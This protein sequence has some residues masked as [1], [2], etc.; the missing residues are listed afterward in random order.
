MTALCYT[1]KRLLRIGCSLG[2]LCLMAWPSATVA[3][4]ITKAN[5]T[6]NIGNAASWV[7]GVAPTSADVMLFDSTIAAVLTTGNLSA[8]YGPGA[9]QITNIGGPLTIGVSGTAGASTALTLNLNSTYAI[10]MSA[11]TADVT[12]GTVVTGGQ[13]RWASAQFGGINVAAGRTL[14]FN[15]NFN[16]QGSTKT[17]AM[18]GGGNIIFNG[19]AGSGGA[20]GFSIQGGTTVTMNGTGAWSGTSAKE[21]INGTLNLGSDTALGAATLTLGGT[22][23]NTPALAATGGARTIANNVTLLASSLGGNPTIVGSNDLTVNGTLTNSGANR[24]L[25]VNNTGLTT[26]GGAVALSEGSSNRTLTLDGTGSITLSGIVGDG[27]TA[28]AS[29]LTYAGS[30][31]LSLSNAN[32]FGG[33]LTATSGT[34]RIDNALAAQNATVSVGSANAVTFGTGITSATFGALSGSGDLALTNTDTND[35]ALSVGG[36][37]AS[38]SYSGKLSGAGTLTK[39]GTGTLTLSGSTSGTVV[40][41][42][43]GGTIALGGSGV[44]GVGTIN[45]AN[46][47]TV[48][49]TTSA[50]VAPLIAVT[51][52]GANVT[53]T[54]NQASNGF[55]SSF[56]GSSDQTLTIS[57]AGGQV[58]N[59]NNTTKQLQGFSG[60]VDLLA[61]ATL[62]DR[63][64][65]TNWQNGSD[66]AVFNV[67]G[68]ITSRNGGNWFLGALTGS[69]TLKM[70]TSGSNGIGLSYSIGARN[71]DATFAGAIEDGDTANGKIVSVTK[72]GTAR[73]TL[74]G[75][76]TY[77]GTTTISAGSLQVGASGSGTTGTGAV[78]VQSGGTILG[79]G[80]VQGSSFTAASG[81]TVQAGDGAAQANYGTLH[82]TPVTSGGSFDFQSGSVTVLGI[83]PGGTSDKL[84]FTG[85]GTQTLVFNGN[86]TVGPTSFTPIAAEVF[87]LM[88]WSGLASTSFNSRFTNTGL[89]LGNGDEASGLDLP[90]ISGSGFFW[91]ISA[92][93]TDG[94]IAIVIVPEPSRALLL[95]AGL[96]G[97]FLRRHRGMGHA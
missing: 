5:N 93:T 89:L 9:L 22:N 44:S 68:T 97:L 39:T 82:F 7:G 24:T 62:S 77:S 71:T 95:L 10:D 14:T 25:S 65:T 30:G 47:T 69:G 18:T 54:S 58:V 64:S 8:N 12:L 86:L 50:G 36:N 40:A 48:S 55:G 21:V 79:T 46:G 45:A 3:A 75:A 61:G 17:I 31:L 2:C 6:T 67:D 72:T 49:L 15:A 37:N 84:S 23:A 80:T 4:T 83:N 87:D 96:L 81:S 85:D 34:T 38:S 94:T 26:F 33:T 66:N 41:N 78:T 70:G 88:D 57:S 11:A 60:T 13:V 73:Q 28:T 27:G 29:S 20:M 1:A 76:N 51:G 59:M 42:L 52:A 19:N 53:L 74:T 32:T 92:F 56:T 91:D 43:N 63:S 90:D 16:N 35:V